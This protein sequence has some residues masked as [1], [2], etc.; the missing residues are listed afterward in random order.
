VYQGHDFET[1]A[2]FQELARSEQE[3]VRKLQA[4]RAELEERSNLTIAEQLATITGLRRELLD[5]RRSTAES[6][7]RAMKC[8]GLAV[9]YRAKAVRFRQ[10]LEAVIPLAVELKVAIREGSE[11]EVENATHYLVKGCCELRP[12]LKEA[13]DDA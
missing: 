4:E 11:L 6:K 9:R 2:A 5:A 3:K 12:L 1:A 10:A 7:E 13:L 8:A